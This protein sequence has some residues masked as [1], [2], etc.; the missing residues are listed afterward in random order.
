MHCLYVNYNKGY[1]L[2]YDL[3]VKCEGKIFLKTI[4]LLDVFL[5]FFRWSMII[6]STM[7]VYGVYITVKVSIH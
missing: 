4:F 2:G 6:F 1:E 7:I 5:S 3:W